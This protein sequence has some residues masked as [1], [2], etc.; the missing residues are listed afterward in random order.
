MALVSQFVNA[1]DLRASRSAGIRDTGLLFQLGRQLRDLDQ[2]FEF[3]QAANPLRLQQLEETLRGSRLTNDFSQQTFDSRVQR[4]AL[5]T[6]VA[7]DQATVSRATVPNQIENAGLETQQNRIVVAA[8]RLS[9]AEQAAVTPTSVQAQVA[10]NI[11]ALRQLD[12]SRQILAQQGINIDRI[13]PPEVQQILQESTRVLQSINDNQVAPDP[14]TAAQNAQ[15]DDATTERAAELDQ[16]EADLRSTLTNMGLDPDQVIAEQRA[17][18]GATPVAAL[19]NRS[20][21]APSTAAS[22]PGRPGSTP[23]SNG[24]QVL[25]R[26]L[27]P[28]VAVDSFGNPFGAP[29][30][31]PQSTGNGV[32]S[33]EQT[34]VRNVDGGTPVSNGGAIVSELFPNA[35]ITQTRRNANSRLGKAN[36][37]SFHVRTN[38]AVD[39]A[40]IPGVT[41]QEFV[42]RF[43]QSGYVVLEAIDE[44]RNPSPHSTGPH[45]HIVLGNA[46]RRS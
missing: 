40:P 19:P 21:A 4:D 14:V 33:P 15:G 29:P 16:L 20:L 28:N 39:V 35:R 2:Q 45:W 5:S 34:R 23:V 25:T 1:G 6:E 10:N 3:N 38:A 24:Q 36:R 8:D 41:F 27:Q 9:L 43:A 44:V 32:T 46:R 30:P 26:R 37:G 7:R 22:R 12:V 13:V 31:I 42:N 18:S 11:A 17:A